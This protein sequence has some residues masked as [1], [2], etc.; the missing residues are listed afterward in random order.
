MVKISLIKINKSNLAI[1]KKQKKKTNPV[2][3]MVTLCIESHT[4]MLTIFLHI[5]FCSQRLLSE[6][7]LRSPLEV[8][9]TCYKLFG[10]WDTTL[11]LI[12][13]KGL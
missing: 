6:K 8:R 11:T 10:L 7:I 3:K 1:Y 12:Y 4:N 2:A 9:R 5:I 13:D